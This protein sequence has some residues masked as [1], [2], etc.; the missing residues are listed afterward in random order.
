MLG[1]LRSFWRSLTGRG[2]ID[3]ANA[4]FAALD[5]AADRAASVCDLCAGRA[6]YRCPT[7]GEV[8]SHSHEN[9]YICDAHGFVN[10]IRDTNLT[11]RHDVS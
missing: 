6:V 4:Q 10:P 9:D 7:C 3:T 11:G 1:R 2:Y 8:V 5:R